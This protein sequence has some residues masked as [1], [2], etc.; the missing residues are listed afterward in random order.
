[1][2]MPAKLT[3]ADFPKFFLGFDRLENDFF[4]STV[5]GGYP[6][7]NIVKFNQ[8]YRVE[9]AVPGWDKKDIEISLFKNVLSVKGVKKQTENPE[10][11][12]LY[13]GLSGKT[14]TRN[15]KVGDYIELSKAYMERG[16][17]CI[18]LVENLP[19]K[20][21]PVTINIS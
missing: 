15:F 2:N 4:A 21:Q 9:I 8:G 3:M 1:M 11:T 10:E 17:L 18:N 16:L 13:K 6:R 14:F 7:Y 5:D 12:Y 20:E 19:E